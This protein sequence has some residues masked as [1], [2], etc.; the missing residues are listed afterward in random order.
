[1]AIKDRAET[2]APMARIVL[3]GMSVGSRMLIGRLRI[4]TGVPPGVDWSHAKRSP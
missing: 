2:P 3:Q 1:V 4:F